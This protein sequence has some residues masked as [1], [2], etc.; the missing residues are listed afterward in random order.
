MAVLRFIASPVLTEWNDPCTQSRFGSGRHLSSHARCS[1]ET[2]PFFPSML[3][4]SRRRPTPQWAPRLPK[5]RAWHPL[6]T[7]IRTCF[8]RNVIRCWVGVSVGEV[9]HAAS[10]SRS[11]RLFAVFQGSVMSCTCSLRPSPPPDRGAYRRSL[12][13]SSRLNLPVDIEAALAWR[14]RPTRSRKTTPM[15]A[16]S[17]P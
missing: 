2:H 16:P 10:A 4:I 6:R 5:P 1:T 11:A 15:G 3:S 12:G 17:C 9:P 8:R 13:R 7:L 14:K